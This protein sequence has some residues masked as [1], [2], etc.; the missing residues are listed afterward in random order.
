MVHE[1]HLQCT[2]VTWVTDVLTAFKV[3]AN[4]VACL[5]PTT[6]S[7]GK[8]HS[9]MIIQN[10][11]VAGKILSSSSGNSYPGQAAGEG[12]VK[13]RRRQVHWP[14]VLCTVSGNPGVEEGLQHHV[15]QVHILFHSNMTAV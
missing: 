4:N 15:L 5:P 9:H 6:K 12:P 7:K 11:E 13:S 8:S 2:V 14:A 1:L 10:K 3:V